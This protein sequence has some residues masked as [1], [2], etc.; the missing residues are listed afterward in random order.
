MKVLFLDIDG[1][2]NRRG[3]RERCG[4]FI[5]VDRELSNR[6]LKWLRESDVKIVLSSTWRRHPEMHPHLMRAGIEW[7]DTT[8]YLGVARGHE[9]QHWLDQNEGKV[10]HYAI[11]DD[12]SDMLDFQMHR[13]VQTQNHVGLQD[14]HIEKLKTILE[15]Q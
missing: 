9:I 15:T 11:L 1:V 5:G 12:D 10:T 2:L 13:F 14:E 6:L 4:G 3:T 8:P 7:I